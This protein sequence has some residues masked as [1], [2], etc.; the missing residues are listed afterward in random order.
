MA[1]QKTAFLVDGMHTKIVDA[2]T[3]KLY[4][5]YTDFANDYN[6][7]HKSWADKFW[8]NITS[9]IEGSTS[10][11]V[12]TAEPI[13]TQQYYTHWMQTLA[14]SGTL[15]SRD[16]FTRWDKAV[17]DWY[18]TTNAISSGVNSVETMAGILAKNALNQTANNPQ[19]MSELG[20]FAQSIGQ[21]PDSV[22]HLPQDVQN[23]VLKEAKLRE[24]NP[25]WTQF[26]QQHKNLATWMQNEY[27]YA[28]IKDDI[29]PQS[30]IAS[31]LQSGAVG[32]IVS[33]L[34]Q[35]RA[36]IYWQLANGAKL[37]EEQETRARILGAMI[38]KLQPK[39]RALSLDDSLTRGLG[40]MTVPLGRAVNTAATF[41]AVGA[42]VGGAT[43][44][45]AGAVAG[46]GTGITTGFAG[47]FLHAMS[48]EQAGNLVGDVYER[49]GNV[50]TVAATLRA[51]TSAVVNGVGLG[52]I[53]KAYEVAQRTGILKSLAAQ[54]VKTF[55]FNAGTS[56]ADFL[57][58]EMFRRMYGVGNTR[59]TGE[60]I[61]NTV[62][63]GAS[64]G[65]FAT[66]IS[67]PAFGFAGLRMLKD[68]VDSSNLMKRGDVDTQ[69]EIINDMVR[70]TPLDTVEVDP[71]ALSE[72]MQRPE[73]T[74]QDLTDYQRI[75]PNPENFDFANQ[76]GTFVDVPLGEFITSNNEM[77][78]ALLS[79]IRFNGRRSLNEYQRDLNDIETEMQARQEQA[80]GA[81][82]ETT[83]AQTENPNEKGKFHEGGVFNILDDNDYFNSQSREYDMKLAKAEKKRKER[84][85][86]KA[87]LKQQQEERQD[88]QS[89]ID[90]QPVYKASR[91]LIG[92]GSPITRV[93][94]DKFEGDVQA[95][96][97]AHHNGFDSDAEQAF[98]DGI[99]FDNGF[100][101]GG[102]LM[103]AII[104]N[105]SYAEA[106]D[107]AFKSV[108]GMQNF[109]ADETSEIKLDKFI[110]K[111]YRTAQALDALARGE[112]IEARGI[113]D[114][115]TIN[116]NAKERTD[117]L[118]EQ[119]K[120]LEGELTGM[121]VI[122]SGV[123]KDVRSLRIDAYRAEIEKIKAD[124]AEE[125]KKVRRETT[126]KI[127]DRM[128]GK[129]KARE[130]DAKERQRGFV[131]QMKFN[132][133]AAE[134]NV[135][136]PTRAAQNA[137]HQ[138]GFMPIG[139]IRANRD[140][141][142]S[143]VRQQALAADKFY[144]KYQYT[145][146]VEQINHVI[147]GTA[148][149]KESLKVLKD[150]YTTQSQIQRFA[151]YTPKQFVDE[152]AYAQADRILR[153][154][155]VRRGAPT[156]KV[157]QTLTD[158]L[159]GRGMDTGQGFPIPRYSARIWEARG[160]GGYYEP[161]NP[162]DLTIGEYKSAV[163]VLKQ[164]KKASDYQK[165]HY[166]E[167]FKIATQQLIKNMI[168]DIKRVNPEQSDAK[169]FN[170][171]EKFDDR[172]AG[173]RK[174]ILGIQGV[175]NPENWIIHMGGEGRFLHTFFSRFVMEAGDKKA[176]LS[177]EVLEPLHKLRD[178]YTKAEHRQ[179][180]NKNLY[181]EEQGG[182]T[183]SKNDLIGLAM[184][185]GAL[186]NWRKLFSIT[187][188]SDNVPI[189]F[190]GASD[191][192]EDGVTRMLGKYLD[193]R[194]WEFI[195]G[196]WEIFDNLWETHCRDFER[197]RTG[198][199]PE[200]AP[201]HPMNITLADG[202]KMHLDG[203]FF[204]LVRDSR[205]QFYNSHNMTDREFI[206]YTLRDNNLNSYTDYM[207]QQSQYMKRTNKA[208]I[209]DTDYE[210]IV[211]SYL[212]KVIHDLAFREWSFTA[213]TILRDANF[214]NTV[215]TR[216]GDG[217][218]QAFDKIVAPILKQGNPDVLTNPFTP[219]L[220]YAKRVGVTSA[221]G[222]LGTII[223]GL[224]NVFIVPYSDAHYG[225]LDTL[226][227]YAK[228]GIG[229]IWSDLLTFN[230]KEM[231]NKLAQTYELSPAFRE[232]GQTL[233][234][235]IYGVRNK[236]TGAFGQF[237]QNCTDAVTTAM[238]GIDLITLQPQYMNMVE[239]FQREAL[240]AHKAE[241]ASGKY[242]EADALKDAVFRADRAMERIV[243]ASRRYRQSGFIQAPVGSA[244][245]LVSG[246]ASYAV[247]MLNRLIW[248]YEVGVR[249]SI[250]IPL[251]VGT[252]IMPMIVAPIATE[253]LA[254]RSPWSSDEKDA[255][256]P[257]K[258]V[259]WAVYTVVGNAAGM[260]PVVGDAMR[261]GIASLTDQPYYGT[262]L[263]VGVYST[264]EQ[265]SRAVRTTATF[266]SQQL[267]NE[268]VPRN[269]EVDFAQAL[270]AGARL[271]SMST[272]V[273]IGLS[274]TFFNII[275][276]MDGTATPQVRDILRRRPFRERE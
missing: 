246:L 198:F 218:L 73:V 153:K 160:A 70:G 100:P 249:Q 75:V 117:F 174:A 3:G 214:R 260:F 202:T 276:Y 184:S 39:D 210:M 180:S 256:D 77:T 273:P 33:D 259:K 199:T 102:A 230:F 170:P 52:A 46:A 76:T 123:K 55:A 57:S 140:K 232:A 252:A 96:A 114:I 193:K 257:D 30:T 175:I 145:Q 251:V 156:I 116:M 21:N 212:D 110:N 238:R 42:G 51:A 11:P 48:V 65:L 127:Y 79:S 128:S 200:K 203:G 14:G 108:D 187:D 179:M 58:D 209:I 162:N 5:K 247:T 185:A 113:R 157:T 62:V 146:G 269:K 243:P 231:R 240:K 222:N 130:K 220:I 99:A 216:F 34:R 83:Q 255:T 45:V 183:V 261:A 92:E 149:L 131:K 66:L 165:K 59:T 178:M 133:K 134:K 138:L 95:W 119:I 104:K 154:L 126:K 205:S 206:E 215:L 182:I 143:A 84:K 142:A 54:G 248:A 20:K 161:V 32:A 12:R 106:L 72:Y 25:V 24:D 275:M 229:G 41:G 141:I 47:G 31:L 266:A 239:K 253:I 64:G 181:I 226:R 61:Y 129:Q 86:T 227:G 28:R 224:S 43:G 267:S 118:Q 22:V 85:Y 109:L 268:R 158:W 74:P 124:A 18:A 236:P 137:R 4:D 148:F 98:V 191:W 225:V 1:D 38:E 233:E 188:G 69:A 112:D 40:G 152:E 173:V 132:K 271:A 88:M 17:K 155:G 105:P 186:H 190:K 228:Y 172:T 91:E 60:L 177:R 263:P 164:I 7:N 264:V 250:N 167:G 272:G 262:R 115:D 23:D 213:G 90:S 107:D 159:A 29:K 50:P 82:G 168:D 223:Q 44:G 258:V 111:S 207:T 147:A 194:D 122:G 201:L 81:D 49:T 89:Y 10:S 93:V 125:V 254:G 27:N 136:T 169:A 78:D 195:K 26:L 67:A 244:M 135:L 241:V 245:W 150:F 9:A 237:T 71:K 37:S 208:Y 219:V 35:E 176:K 163:E 16:N 97:R 15:Y 217:G 211:P 221:I 6:E 242:T 120:S 101:S 139:K 36:E 144:A 197:A 80:Q 234:N 151:R 63:N 2:E 192:S 87:E 56:S 265:A 235:E 103:V 196:Y 8:D 13:S 274:N 189:A 171:A 19:T 94:E 68:Q 270:E 166:T 204:P 121:G 53:G